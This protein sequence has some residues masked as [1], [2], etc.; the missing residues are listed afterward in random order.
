MCL[1]VPIQDLDFQHHMS[2]S[3]WCSMSSVKMRVDCSF[4]WYWWHWSSQLFKF[5]F[6]ITFLCEIFEI[7][8]DMK[9]KCCRI[10]IYCYI[11]TGNENVFV[12][13]C[14]I[15]ILYIVNVRT[16]YAYQKTTFSIFI[17]SLCCTVNFVIILFFTCDV[18]L[19]Q[20]DDI[21]YMTD[22][23]SAHWI[24][25]KQKQIKMWFTLGQFLQCLLHVEPLVLV[26]IKIS[27]S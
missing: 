15:G 25:T 17:G 24:Q 21:L 1:P 20:N 16:I 22:T 9:M 18:F 23:I 19:S 10:T 4:C 8:V 2:W 12:M 7:T 5:L 6:V 14:I 26:E 27:N 3:F 11:Y 13:I